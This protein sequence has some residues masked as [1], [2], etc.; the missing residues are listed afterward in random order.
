MYDGKRKY[1]KEDGSTVDLTYD[2]LVRFPFNAKLKLLGDVS[3]TRKVKIAGKKKSPQKT[4][5][6]VSEEDDKEAE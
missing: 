4:D 5:M 2:E 6:A 3:P 1:E